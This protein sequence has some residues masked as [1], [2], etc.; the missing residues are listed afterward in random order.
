MRFDTE[1]L[2]R[3][4]SVEEYYHAE[5]GPP[6]KTSNNHF[7][8]S[9]C[10]HGDGENPNL[11]V[12]KNGGFNCL[13][14]KK[15]G[16][17]II[18]FHMEHHNLDFQ[19]ACK[20]L[21][22]KY[23]I[24]CE[25]PSSNN[26]GRSTRKLD[27]VHDFPLDALEYLHGRDLTD[28]T[29]K[30]FGL[31]FTKYKIK[32]KAEDAIT[33]PI[34]NF[35]KVK[36]YKI[37]EKGENWRTHPRGS[38]ATFFGNTTAQKVVLCAGEWDCM[39]LAQ[40]GFDAVT[41]TAGE[42]TFKTVWI[43]NFKDKSVTIIYDN[44]D[45]GREGALG[46]AKK[47]S[48]VAKEIRI[49]TLPEELGDAGDITDFFKKGYAADDLRKLISETK[50]LDLE[51]IK[52]ANANE[53][54]YSY[55]GHLLYR[56][57]P[58]NEGKIPVPIANFKAYVT[59]DI[60]LD[61]GIEEK[62]IF[63]IAGLC[64]KEFF[65]PVEV[66]SNKFFG[67]GWVNENWGIKAVIFPPSTN[68]DFIRHS[69]QVFSDEVEHHQVFTHTG[70]REI[71]GEWVYL[72]SEGA[73]GKDGVAVNLPRELHKYALPTEI[74]SELA[75]AGMKASLSFLDIAPLA[76]TLPLFST[77]YLSPLTSIL[78][79]FPP[80]SVFLSGESGSLKTTLACLALCHFGNFG[81]DGLSNFHDTANALEKRAF[82]LKDLPMILD[83]LHPSFNNREAMQREAVAQRL[84]REYANRTGRARLNSDAIEKGRYEPRGMLIITG[85]NLPQ[86][87]STGARFW[88]I[89]VSKDQIDLEKLTTL[90]KESHLLPHAT[91][92]YI[93]WLRGR[94]DKIRSSFPKEMV[95]LRDQVLGEYCHQRIK[96]QIAYLY[97]AFNLSLEWFVSEGI[98]SEDAAAKRAKDAWEILLESAK[99]QEHRIQVEN[100]V[101]QFLEIFEALRSQGK[102]KLMD[103]N[104]TENVI[105]GDPSGEFVGYA[106]HDFYY[107]LP[108]QLWHAIK[109]FCRTEGTHLGLRERAINEL[110]KKRGY[111]ETAQGRPTKLERIGT[112]IK[113]VLKLN[114]SCLEKKS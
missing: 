31:G 102:I 17:D 101:K 8:Y 9:C 51:E 69:V 54:P 20:E 52:E 84:I 42:N 89:E 73:I 25:V 58:T 13:S 67:M 38:K 22:E 107:L 80:F 24:D 32:G 62:R 70:W 23:N 82:V 49:V 6:E 57:K 88:G 35:H 26:N 72:T 68:R 98:L 29:I 104:Q 37:M 106:D 33:I 94:L 79:P 28:E 96:E 7:T 109:V 59:K 85:E 114:K 46:T 61:D 75:R 14:C 66:P 77:M 92:S 99:G 36:L 60:I 18:A 113:R 90:Q 50:P 12:F 86:G 81:H 27:I 44:D 74:D 1:K 30:R 56:S 91:A 63:E 39:M 108:T 15:S 10:F 11:T 78:K 40:N 100:P 41:G 97:W 110:L 83:D 48:I 53:S 103:K 105:D 55:D 21:T 65:K 4:I 76:I 112:Q 71:D 43:E 5:L 95:E 93:N 3:S 2:K 19:S 47:I 64:G 45:A 111:T 34:G 87:T 16:G